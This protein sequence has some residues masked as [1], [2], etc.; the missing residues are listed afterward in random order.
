MSSP[1]FSQ[2]RMNDGGDDDDDDDKQ[3][4]RG[5]GLDTGV[6]GGEGSGFWGEDMQLDA[7]G[8]CFP[9]VVIVIQN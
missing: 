3:Q 9:I 4:L 2:L 1:F 8:R 6:G 7:F 5:L